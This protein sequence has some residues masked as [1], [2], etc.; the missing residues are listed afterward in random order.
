MDWIGWLGLP[1]CASEA[2]RRKRVYDSAVFLHQDSEASV[3]LDEGER[4]GDVFLFP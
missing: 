3:V 2:G 1:G 4:V